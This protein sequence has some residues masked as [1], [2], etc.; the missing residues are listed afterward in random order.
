VEQTPAEGSKQS[1]I[2]RIVMD[3]LGGMVDSSRDF[4]EKT[5]ISHAMFGRYK[6]MKTAMPLDKMEHIFSKFPGLQELV[7]RHLTGNKMKNNTQAENGS[8]STEKP[9]E[10]DPEVYRT[11][12][13]GKTEYVLMKRSILNDAQIVSN[14]QLNATIR[15]MDAIITK[16]NEDSRIMQILVSKFVDTVEKVMSA[17]QPMQAQKGK[18]HG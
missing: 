8:D 3:Y 5:G 1:E 7:V 2:Q 15:N 13:E 12:V 11:I 6:D 10:G 14:V 9:L 17:P 18:N 4:E 16:M